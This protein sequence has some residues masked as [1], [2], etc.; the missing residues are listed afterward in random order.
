MFISIE[1]LIKPVFRNGNTFKPDNFSLIFQNGAIFL[2][3]DVLIFN[4]WKIFMLSATVTVISSPKL[5][6]R[7]CH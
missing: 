2:S 4:K 3:N 1:F 6:G 5:E 7:I